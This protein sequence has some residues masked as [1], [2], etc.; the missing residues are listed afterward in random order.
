M[1]AQH[2][3]TCF[4]PLLL[5]SA[6]GLLL[7]QSPLPP[8]GSRADEQ[9]FN[10]MHWESRS[11]Q[12]HTIK[13]AYRKADIMAAT[14]QIN[15]GRNKNCEALPDKGFPFQVQKPNSSEWLRVLRGK[16]VVFLGD[17]LVR[18]FF[19]SFVRSLIDHLEW[20]SDVSEWNGFHFGTKARGNMVKATFS[21]QVSAEFW[22]AM[23][24]NSGR[25]WRDLRQ[26]DLVIFGLGAHYTDQSLLMADISNYWAQAL[27]QLAGHGGL[28]WMEY[29]SPHFPRGNGEYEDRLARPSCRDAGRDVSVMSR[30]RLSADDFFVNEG[31]PILRTWNASRP[32]WNNHPESLE[33]GQDLDC[34]HWCSPGLALDVWETMLWTLL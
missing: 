24:T 12:E 26:A 15:P 32:L 33:F 30:M 7:S 21:E 16:R 28:V 10:Y 11:L 27:K 8:S 20:H 19:L 22:W 3:M 6:S 9:Q 5:H 25:Q 31:V 23:P 4:L 18:D 29:P 1:W 34:R 14:L 13:E 2:M 17:S